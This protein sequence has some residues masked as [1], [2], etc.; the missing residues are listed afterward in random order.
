MVPLGDNLGNRLTDI[1]FCFCFC[2]G[3]GQK[4]NCQLSKPLTAVNGLRAA[5]KTMQTVPWRVISMLALLKFCC[6]WSGAGLVSRPR[7]SKPLDGLPATGAS[8]DE[9]PIS[10]VSV[11]DMGVHV[12]PLTRQPMR[13]LYCTSSAHAT[14]LDPTESLEELVFTLDMSLDF[15]PYDVRFNV[16]LNE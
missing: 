15:N 11:R 6:L 3:T 9:R 14:H 8:C 13:Q 10:W 7:S 4:T 16:E 2:Y 12:A 5:R 1:G